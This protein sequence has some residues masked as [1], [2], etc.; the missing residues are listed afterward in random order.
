M[1]LIPLAPNFLNDLN[2]N[3][4]IL[5][6]FVIKKI[7]LQNNSALAYI[8]ISKYIFTKY[9]I[10]S[11]Y[12]L[13]ALKQNLYIKSAAFCYKKKKKKVIYTEYY[14]YILNVIS[15]NMLRASNIW[16]NICYTR[17]FNY[18]FMYLLY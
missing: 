7:Y 16:L 4:T 8:I 14:Y 5:L 2:V 18:L 11:L 12:A 6:L 10:N 17:C 1:A 15:A 13:Q 3:C 9:K